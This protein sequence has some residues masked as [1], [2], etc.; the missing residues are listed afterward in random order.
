MQFDTQVALVVHANRSAVD[1]LNFF[2]TGHQ[3]RGAGQQRLRQRAKWFNVGGEINGDTANGAARR[4]PSGHA[5]GNAPLL[6][7]DHGFLLRQ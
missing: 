3:A 7:Y 4:L 1:R 2:V 6:S 5:R